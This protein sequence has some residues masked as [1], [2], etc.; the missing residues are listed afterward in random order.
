ML[1]CPVDR[2]SYLELDQLARQ[3]E[4]HSKVVER[5]FFQD[6]DNEE[7]FTFNLLRDKG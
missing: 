3:L 2:G 6:A 5:S 1:G 4:C 7:V